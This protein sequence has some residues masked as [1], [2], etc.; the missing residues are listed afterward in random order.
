M[1]NIGLSIVAGY[2]DQD[3]N[4]QREFIK[5]LELSVHYKQSRGIHTFERGSNYFTFF[6]QYLEALS[7]ETGDTFSIE[8]DRFVI[9]RRGNA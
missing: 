4:G 1:T 8:G 6:S 7:P 9:R 3:I 5:T 2:H